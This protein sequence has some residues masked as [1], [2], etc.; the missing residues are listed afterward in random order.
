MIDNML[1]ESKFFIVRGKKHPFTDKDP[2]FAITQ[3]V[4]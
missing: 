1:E 3:A 4:P 2:I